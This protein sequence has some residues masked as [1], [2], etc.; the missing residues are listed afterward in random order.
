MTTLTYYDEDYNVRIEAS[1]DKGP[2]WN[3]TLDE[4][5]VT[6]QGK[7][8]FVNFDFHTSGD[9]CNIYN[10]TLKDDDI[11]EDEQAALAKA[12]MKDPEVLDTLQ[13]EIYEWWHDS[14]CDHC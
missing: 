8:Y 4:I 9:F 2:H 6:F 1:Y 14:V 7:S 12:M 3:D 13:D 11:P 5:E 10:V